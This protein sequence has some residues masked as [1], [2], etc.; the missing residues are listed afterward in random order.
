MVPECHNQDNH[1][2]GVS[3]D[4]NSGLPRQLWGYPLDHHKVSQGTMHIR[5][6]QNL[7]IIVKKGMHVYFANK[8]TLPVWYLKSIEH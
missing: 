7:V 2:G 5:D 1:Q 4:S 8:K 3:I 6:Q